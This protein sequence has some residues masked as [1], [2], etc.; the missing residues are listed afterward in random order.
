MTF[1]TDLEKGKM[2]EREVMQYFS[3]Y[4][5][6]VQTEG[7]VPYDLELRAKVEV[8]YDRVAPDTGRYAIELLCRGKSSGLSNTEARTWVLCTY[9]GCWM[10]STETLREWVKEFGQYNGEWN[11]VMGGDDKHSSLILIPYLLVKQF[12]KII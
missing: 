7:N 5:E 11:F 4:Y 1:Q 8:K 9:E 12:K 10:V 6:V 3:K 2:K